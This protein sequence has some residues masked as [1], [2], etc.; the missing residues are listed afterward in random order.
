MDLWSKSSLYNVIFVIYPF[1]ELGQ[2][3]NDKND[4]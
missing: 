4:R 3:A 2:I 1:A